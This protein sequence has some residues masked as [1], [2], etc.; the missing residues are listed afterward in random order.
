M[1][2]PNESFVNVGC[3]LSYP[4]VLDCQS[5]S[6]VLLIDS[7]IKQSNEIDKQLISTVLTNP[8][9]AQM[10]QYFAYLFL[11]INR[12]TIIEDTLNYFV[13]EDV[14]FRKPLRIKFIGELGV[15]E[16]GVQKEFFQL[17]IRKLFD[18]AYTMF[19][20]NQ[21]SRMLWFNGNTFEANV[22]FELLG[23]L[24]GIAIYNQ[25]ILDLHL[26]M[27]CFKKLLDIQP[28]LSD[29]HEYMPAV[30]QSLEFINKSEDPNLEQLL[31]QPFTVELDMF[32]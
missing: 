31:Y 25:N 8:F 4:W 26:P 16:G 10:D 29:L 23:I 3:V 30:A 19:T 17:L 6:D 5:K 1:D 13:R 2:D 11:E 24:L 14:N 32:G 18:P 27:A 15:D 7:R 12:E 9:A 21:E 28:T 22:K 20:Y